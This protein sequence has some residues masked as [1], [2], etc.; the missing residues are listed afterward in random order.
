[1]KTY[2]LPALLKA[3][4]EAILSSSNVRPHF[5]LGKDGTMDTGKVS[6]VCTKEDLLEVQAALN[7]LV[8]HKDYTS[9][10]KTIPEPTPPTAPWP[11]LS[12]TSPWPGY[13]TQILSEK[14]EPGL[15]A[16]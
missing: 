1:M 2:L 11:L 4:I 14:I 10:L 6:V 7:F 12:P 5:Q 16:K 9:L 15:E 8:E 3:K 13:T